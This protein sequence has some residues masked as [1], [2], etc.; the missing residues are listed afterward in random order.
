[1]HF[2]FSSSPFYIAHVHPPTG[3]DPVPSS[4]HNNPKFWPFFNDA[5]AVIDGSHIHCAPPTFEQEF[6][7]NHKGFVSQNCLFTYF[8]NLEFVYYFMGWEGSASNAQVYNDAHSKDLHIPDRKYYLANEEFP[9]GQQL[10]IP[11]CGSWY[12]L[13]EWGCANVRYD[14]LYFWYYIAI[15]GLLIKKNYLICI[16]HHFAM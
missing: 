15:T 12:H 11:Y 10:L 14:I 8:F 7:W 1:M 2:I 3:D 16:M 9:M 13:A 5:I 6:Y 4:I